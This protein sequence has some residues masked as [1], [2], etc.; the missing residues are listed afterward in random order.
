MSPRKTKNR[1][2]SVWPVL[3]DQCSAS[4]LLKLSLDSGGLDKPY[5]A[6]Q[7]NKQVNNWD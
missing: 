5:D 6:E 3:Q 1:V 4:L 2:V 7:A